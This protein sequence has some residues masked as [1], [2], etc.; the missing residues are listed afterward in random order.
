MLRY[1]VNTTLSYE[2][3]SSSDNPRT[4]TFVPN[5]GVLAIYYVTRTSLLRKYYNLLRSSIIVVIYTFGH[6]SSHKI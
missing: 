5:S 2:D 6:L 3:K 1:S 4:P